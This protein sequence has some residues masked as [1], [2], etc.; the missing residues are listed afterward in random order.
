MTRVDKCC[1]LSGKHGLAAR[2][3]DNVYSAP[4]PIVTAAKSTRSDKNAKLGVIKD[5]SNIS[6]G[7]LASE[8][9]SILSASCTKYKIANPLLD[10]TKVLMVECL[11][12]VTDDV[13]LSPVG[14]QLLALVIKV[15][16]RFEYHVKEF[17]GVH[18]SGVVSVVTVPCNNYDDLTHFLKDIRVLQNWITNV[19]V[20]L[21][22]EKVYGVGV[23]MSTSPIRRCLERQS[24]KMLSVVEAAWAHIASLISADCIA[25]LTAL[26]TIAGKYRMT[27]KPPPDTHSSF[28]PDILKPLR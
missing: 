15:L 10:I 16:N 21:F 13:F 1:D 2:L 7:L 9:A 5:T 17:L 4:A 3:W 27:N 11:Y 22:E 8:A 19:L 26:K 24:M 18:T 23:A 20:S 28:V 6:C 25:S 14:G 12:C